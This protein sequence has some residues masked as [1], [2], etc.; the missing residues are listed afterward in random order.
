VAEVPG[1]ARLQIGGGLSGEVA[2]EGHRRQET[3]DPSM[4]TTCSVT[5][6][7]AGPAILPGDGRAPSEA[8]QHVGP[9]HVRDGLDDEAIARSA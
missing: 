4:S 8:P 1:T 7:G 6:A 5:P 2:V 9:V 3:V